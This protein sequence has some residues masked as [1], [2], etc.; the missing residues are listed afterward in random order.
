MYISKSRAP[1]LDLVLKKIADDKTMTLFISIAL[2][3]ADRSHGHLR[4]MNLTKKQY[5]SR[6]SGLL[7]SGLIKRQKGE[8][9]LT[10]FGRVVYD[11]QVTI[12]QA[13]NYYWKLKSIES[14]QNSIADKELP[15][16]EL[17]KIIDTLI[18]N[19]KIKDN[20]MRGLLTFEDNPA[21]CHHYQ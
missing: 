8:Y 16:T 14:I 3:K 12:G 15:P 7:K 4:I 1:A 5:Y 6:V 13:L 17:L 10:L 11:A 19:H 20:L 21:N 2:S 9:S 18:D